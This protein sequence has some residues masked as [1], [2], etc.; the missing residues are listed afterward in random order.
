MR[1]S[2]WVVVPALLVLLSAG[3]RQAPA[4]AKR[5][6]DAEVE[7]LIAE[8]MSA[9]PEFAADVLIRTA[10][11]SAIADVAWRRELLEEAFRRAYGAQEPYRRVAA[12]ISPDTRQGA[13]A[14]AA[15]TPLNRVALQV[16]SVQLMRFFDPVRARELFGWIELNLDA[17]ACESPLAPALDEY[18]L[19][20]ATLARQTFPDTPQGRADALA[21]FELFL[22]RARVPSEVPAVARAMRRF[23]ANA[24]EAAYL[25]ML[26]RA[27]LE[28]G[29][30]GPRAFSTSAIDIGS[31][32]SE[33][34]DVDRTLGVGG[35]YLLATLR[36]YLV[37][38]LTGP[39]CSD[40][41]TDAA[42][43]ELFNAI[44][45][46]ERSD[47]DGVAPISAGDAQPSKRLG[48]VTLSPY[49]TT[50]DARR[51][52]DDA[53]S[54]RGTGKAPLPLTVRRSRSWL[55]QADRHL[56]DVQQWSSTREAAERDHF[57][58]KAAL[59]VELIDL[60]P[61]GPT[62]VRTLRAFA[63][64]L[65][66]NDAE[67]RRALWFFFANR[68]IERIESEDGPDVL[69]AIDD[70]GDQVLSLYAHAARITRINQR[71]N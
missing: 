65:H 15:D 10:E 60:V 49:W 66:H 5:S 6:R 69:Q 57:Y 62:R 37:T 2:S 28:N 9:P 38:Q 50:P 1:G 68:L 55:E 56:V 61:S 8:A 26:L 52:H 71:P 24:D 21:F 29:E 30:R 53:V 20:L 54:L 14:L 11:S 39:R 34:R 33:L 63:D 36:Q 67:R 35:P 32:I 19:A 17:D 22:W 40:S 25:E 59:F 70:T 64:F 4:L 16:R 3:D 46:R 48:A 45:S 23:R 18:H 13:E 47:L 51:L 27:M 41:L 58:Q 43:V 42:V 44:V 31:Q 12:P 7:V